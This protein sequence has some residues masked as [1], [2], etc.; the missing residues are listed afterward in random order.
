MA[1]P[2]FTD[3]GKEAAIAGC[4]AV[5]T[6]EAIPRNALV[7]AEA[8][9]DT[10]WRIVYSA[11]ITMRAE[12]SATVVSA[13][14]INDYIAFHGLDGQLQR[15]IDSTRT[16]SWQHW[17]ARADISVAYAPEGAAYCLAEL[18]RLYVKRTLARLGAEFAA[19]D[20]EIE[21]ACT[22]IEAL[23]RLAG[24]KD[25]LP[26]IV[27]AA[28]L[29]LNPPAPPPEIIA[30][31]LHRG[32]K[33]VLGGGSKSFKTWLLLDL[34]YRAAHGAPWFGFD[35]ASGPTLYLNFELPAFAIQSRLRELGAAIDLPIPETLHL[36]NLRGYAADATTILPAICAEARALNPE[37]IVLDP[38]YKIL[39]PR[40]E[41]ASRDMANLM[42]MI[43]RLALDTGAAVV[44]GAHFAKGNA[45]L[46]E[47]IDRFSGS[48]V[49]GRD[50]DSI[51]TLTQHEEQNAFAVDMILRNFPQQTPFAV[52]WEHPLMVID[53]KLDPAD[54]KKPRTGRP[55]EHTVEELLASLTEPRTTSD[56]LEVSDMPKSTFHRLRKEA[57]RKG[58][59]FKSQI[60][61]KW[62]LKL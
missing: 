38:L 46:K 36:W 62:S 49:I 33:M 45:S 37:L 31:V 44:F 26:V 27:T 53:N 43:E 48:G 20:A 39:G 52:R 23:R 59:I 61:Q 11:A 41:N 42:N 14:S 58:L 34:A 28:A 25:L 18:K 51:V 10:A 56:W 15:A 13:E 30:G 29:C 55:P 7:P 21:E 24:G 4:I 3:L 57:L 2:K 60:D 54:L 6:F 16:F 40:D 32:S 9:T 35:T 8:F 12:I 1:F 50:P 22:R 5:G 19:G 47:A 17:P